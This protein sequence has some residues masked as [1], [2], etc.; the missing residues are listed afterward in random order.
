M[1][2]QISVVITQ[3]LTTEV[4]KTL[5]SR[6]S[7]EKSNPQAPILRRMATSAEL[8]SNSYKIAIILFLDA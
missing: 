8:L 3:L 4:N 7:D 6:A 1:N 5:N 2:K